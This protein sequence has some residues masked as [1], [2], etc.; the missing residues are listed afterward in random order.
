MVEGRGGE[1][2][3]RVLGRGKRKFESLELGNCRAGQTYW[4][5]H[6]LAPSGVRAC[7]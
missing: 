1:G 7:M 5:K 3:R 4:L 6:M 2:G